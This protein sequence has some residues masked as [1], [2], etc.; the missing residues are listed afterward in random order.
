[1]G[2]VDPTAVALRWSTHN[3]IHRRVYRVAY[4]NA[5]WHMDSNMSLIRWGLVIHGAIDGYSRLI[6]YLHCSSNNR[7]N[8]VLHLFIQAGET[9]G[10]PSRMRSDQ[11]GENVDVARLMLLLRGRN[12][13]SH[14][15]GRSVNNIRIERLW[16]DVFSQC[17]SVYYHLFYFMEDSG[18]LDPDNPVHLYALHHIYI[19]RINSSLA[20]FMEAWNGHPLRTATNLSPFQ[21]WIRGILHHSHEMNPPIQELFDR[22]LDSNV[23]N[24]TSPSS[25]SLQEL[26]G[27]VNPLDYSDTWGIDLYVQT[28]QFLFS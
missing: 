11:G 18:I 4:P 16:R 9:Y 14:I 5:L 20:S 15:T 3:A 1:M 10:Y 28:L 23:D 17:L 2:R 6:V 8:T 27:H 21:L 24:G 7:P 12:R 26:E 22:S 13:G 19:V 25:P